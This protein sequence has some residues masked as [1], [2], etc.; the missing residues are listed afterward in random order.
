[1]QPRWDYCIVVILFFPLIVSVAE[2][3]NPDSL[4]V[5]IHQ[6]E[7]ESHRWDVLKTHPRIPELEKGAELARRGDMN[8][9]IRA[10]QKAAPARKSYAYFNLGVVYFE[11][12]NFSRARRYFQLS[13][14]ARRDPV[15][16]E[17]LLNSRRLVKERK[18]RR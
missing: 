7:S 12:G 9:A 18:S 15:C 5:G 11:A 13:Y 10:F 1:M 17:Y 6:A 4:N 3:Q 8:G 16:L 14:N 2:A